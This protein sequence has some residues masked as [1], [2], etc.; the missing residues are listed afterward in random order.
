MPLLMEALH[1]NDLRLQAVA[2]TAL[3]PNAAGQLAAEMPKLSEAARLRILGLLAERGD[4]SALPAFTAALNSPSRPVRLAALQGAGSVGD[5]S[6]ISV[7]AGIAAAG[8]DAERNA[9]RASLARI[10]GKAS[11]QMVADSLRKTADPKVKLELIRAAGE[12]GATAAAPALLESARDPSDEIRRES[13]RALRDAGTASE[14]PG[15][16]ALVVKPAHADDRTEAAR[17]LSVVRRRADPSRIQEVVS[18]Y[19][20]AS[21]VETRAAL[22][23]VMGQSGHAEA[24]P[25]LRTALKDENAEMKRAAILALTEWPDAAPVPD[26]LETARTSSTPAH[27]ILAV[28]GALRLI[29]LPESNRPPAETVKFLASAMSL[30][31]EVGEKRSILSMLQRYPV[32]EALDLAKASLNDGAVAAEA[33]QAVARIERVLK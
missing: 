31:K 24:L 26:L 12:R 10:R 9:A 25:I 13:L 16:I 18:A 30:A 19:T 15:L 17:S 3:M 1:G 22:L 4:A 23:Q 14:I 21:D 20:Q 5:A 32:K 28:R 2:I 11:D 27:Q 33:K 29:G 6:V 8:D 7:L